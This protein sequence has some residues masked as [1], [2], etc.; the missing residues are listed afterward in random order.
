MV[1][2]IITISSPVFSKDKYFKPKQQYFFVDKIWLEPSCPLCEDCYKS[3][4]ILHYRIILD[5]EA[6][7]IPEYA[8]VIADCII[9]PHKQ[10]MRKYKE[11][12]NIQQPKDFRKLYKEVLGRDI[13]NEYKADRNR[14]KEIASVNFAYYGNAD[15]TRGVDTKKV[16][17]QEMACSVLP[18]GEQQSTGY[19]YLPFSVSINESSIEHV[20]SGFIVN[21]IITGDKLRYKYQW[22]TGETTEKVHI[23][24]IYSHRNELI[25]EDDLG[26]KKSAW[27]ELEASYGSFTFSFSKS[28]KIGELAWDF[29]N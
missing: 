7:Y 10:D 4:I 13:S 28:F 11:W 17:R 20:G 9:P 26:C 14:R 15:P 5:G 16:L 24:N 19:I 1:G 27:Y 18:P 8:A 12:E 21:P 6:Y 22:S 29:S 2:N 3:K 23:E 25:V